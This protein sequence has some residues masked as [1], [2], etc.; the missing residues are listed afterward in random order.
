M[1]FLIEPRRRWS[2]GRVLAVVVVVAA[3]GIGLHA[4]LGQ[5]SVEVDLQHAR[6]AN[7]DI[8][9]GLGADAGTSCEVHA[10]VSG[11]NQVQH[12]TGPC[13]YAKGMVVQA[14]VSPKGRISFSEPHNA[15]LR[16]ALSIIAGLLWF[17][18]VGGVGGVLA[19]VGLA[20]YRHWEYR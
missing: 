3:L 2:G 10:K 11:S 15:G 8:V 16:L 14:Y 9:F 13:T 18:V 1:P 17:A 4:F 6:L 7:V 5:R 12:L 19:A 20:A